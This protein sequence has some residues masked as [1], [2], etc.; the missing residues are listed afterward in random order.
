MASDGQ[1]KL[2]SQLEHLNARYV[3]TGHA[4]ITRH[5]WAEHQHRDSIASYLGHS[6]IVE[7]FALAEGVSV[8]RARLNLLERLHRPVGDPP[9]PANADIQVI[10]ADKKTKANGTAKQSDTGAANVDANKTGL[11]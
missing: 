9:K 5:E 7:Y 11:Q 3:G 6:S 8:G 4:D 2:T 1:Q 10:A